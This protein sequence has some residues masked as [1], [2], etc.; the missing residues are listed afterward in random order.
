MHDLVEQLSAYPAEQRIAAALLTLADKM[1]E[2]R[3]SS[4]LIQAPL[5]R[6]DLAEMTGTTPETA[7]RIMAQFRHSGLVRTGRRWVAILDASRLTAEARGE[8]KSALR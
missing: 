5:S 3:G 6:Q 8:Q 2:T 4:V 1:G 7:S